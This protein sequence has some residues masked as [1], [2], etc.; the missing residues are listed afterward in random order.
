M[1]DHQGQVEIVVVL[2]LQVVLNVGVL[3][4]VVDQEEEQ[5]EEVQEEVQEEHLQQVTQ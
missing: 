1:Q 3:E 4:E 2:D 5:E